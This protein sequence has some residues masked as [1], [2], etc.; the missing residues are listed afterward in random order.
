M[1][2]I[3]YLPPDE[4]PAEAR[5]F[6]VE[7]VAGLRG[8]ELEQTAAGLTLRVRP[9]ALAPTLDQLKR[10]FGSPLAKVYVRAERRTK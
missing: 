8:D 10:R 9:E 7:C 4:E 2:E 6:L 1:I 3:V 5:C